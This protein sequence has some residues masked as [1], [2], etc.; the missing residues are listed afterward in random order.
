LESG[1]PFGRYRLLDLLGR[2]GMGEV[3]RAF[4]T[5]TERV[6][7]LKVLPFQY[8]DDEV[9]QERFRREAKSA[10][11]LDEP[12][13]V[14]IHDFGEIEG[15]LFVTMRLIQGRDLNGILRDGR[16]ESMRAVGIIEQVA[17]ALNAAHRV[18]LVHRDVKPSNILVTD[19]DFAYLIDFGLARAAGQTSITG[20]RHIVG[21]W[22]YMAPERITDETP[23]PRADI[24]ALAC[25]LYECLTGR[26]PFGGDTM[27][28]QIGGHLTVPPPRPSERHPDVPARLDAVIAR[29][30]AKNPDDRYPTT[31]ELAQAAKAA[32]L[33]G[34][35]RMPAPPPAPPAPRPPQ[36]P[37]PGPPPPYGDVA[38]PPMPPP[39]GPPPPVSPAAATQYGPMPYGP[40]L[41]RPGPPPPP[42]GGP[43]HTAATQQRSLSGLNLPGPPPEPVLPPTGSLPADLTQF[44]QIPYGLNLPASGPQPVQV[45]S[46]PPAKPNTGR[47]L[48]WALGAVAVIAAV[49]VAGV[50]LSGDDGGSSA[51]SSTSTTPSPPAN[52]GPFTGAFTADMGPQTALN[53]SNPQ[54]S[55]A[56]ETWRLRSDCG[57]TGCVATASTAGEFPV[58]DL[59]FDKG[60]DGWLAVALSRRKCRNRDDDEAWNIVWVQP[61]P[62][63]AMS[64]EWTQLTNNGCGK[65]RTVTLTRT[66]DT[67]ISA[68]PDPAT[69]PARV[70]SPAEGLHGRYDSQATFANGHKNDPL[71]Y[72]V[73]TDC[74]RTG[75]RC[76]SHF[77]EANAG[78]GEAFVFA[79]GAWTRNEEFDTNCSSGGT[80]H[81][82]FT[83]TL[84]LP[85]PPQNPIPLLTGHGYDEVTSGSGS[86]CKSQ[87]FD[88]TFTRTGD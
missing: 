62:S 59:V 15:R 2:G 16:I 29:G 77:Y 21:T 72:T 50:V 54:P 27:E 38:R 23:D 35:T 30:M 11:G 58:K 14:P 8:A 55:G 56:S 19:D 12:H 68:L 41:Q 49:V 70:V 26:K 24:Y 60:G 20:R 40:G 51:A 18:N 10:A 88:Q 73:H 52:T 3:W 82:I 37:Y 84:P 87:A 53:G 81:V 85:Q 83:A 1:T 6:V 28:Q 78:S 43:S 67:E 74:L 80:N 66:G 7:A 31:R 47:R 36:P 61:Q 42:P 46:P 45:P 69:L 34:S 57:A 44:R 48:A 63:G 65:K 79:N 17:S 71:H 75:D 5:V 13:V 9:F 39:G 32:L 33:A 86:K 4:D 25:V 22:A 76:M 64:G